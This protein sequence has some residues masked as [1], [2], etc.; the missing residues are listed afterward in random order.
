MDNHI[1]KFGTG[2]CAEKISI[3]NGTSEKILPKKTHNTFVGL[4]MKILE[5]LNKI[6]H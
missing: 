2:T 6:T 1:D 4:L 3:Q 5:I